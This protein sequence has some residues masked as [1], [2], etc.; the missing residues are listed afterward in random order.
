MPFFGGTELHDVYQ[1]AHAGGYGMVASNVTHPELLYGLLD[2]AARSKT[3]LVLQVKRD[4]LEYL[5]NGDVATGLAIV[6]DLLDRL[7]PAVGV[8]LNVDHIRADD[9]ELRGVAIDSDVPSSIMIDASHL[10]FEQN[11]ETTNAVVET[12]RSRDGTT[13]VEAELGRIAGTE[14]GTITGEAAH[15]DP[16]EAVSFVE[17]TGCDLL[18][19]SIGTQH[20]V[21]AG[22]DP[23]LRIDRARYIDEALQR[24]GH[25]VP[26]VVHGSSGL[27]AADVAALLET[28]VCKLNTNT[29]Y[30]YEYA[31]TACEFYHDHA[32]EIVPPASVADDR[33]TLF[34]AASWQPDKAIFDPRVVGRQLREDIGSVYEELAT[35]AGSRGRSH[36][37]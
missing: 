36:W 29:R 21:A 34:A 12:V 37:V 14:S 9:T 16:A 20:G 13:L 30:Q 5:G 35:V 32:T 23:E 17:Q 3:D 15:T 19:I 7:A 33:E 8:F 24:A 18:A 31:R 22:R 25:D 1:T 4:T 26:L 27:T 2:G 11:V 28:G 10:P 6:G